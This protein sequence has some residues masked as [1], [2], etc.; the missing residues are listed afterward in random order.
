[1]LTKKQNLLET[2]RHGKPDRYVNQYEAFQM[3]YGNPYTAAY[4]MAAEGGPEVVNG[5]GVTIKFPK[6]MPG[7]FPVHDDAHIVCKDITHWRDYVKA[8]NIKFP[9]AAWEPFMAEVEKIDRN[10]YF[11]TPFVAPGIFEQCHYL[12]EIQ[13]CLINFYEEPEAMH[14]LIDYITEWEMQYAEELCRHFHPDALFHHDDWG[15]QISS[16]LSPDMFEEFYVPAYKKVYGYY[17]ELGVDVIVHHSDSYAANLVPHM[18]DIGI[19]IWQGV[20]DTNNIPELIDKYGDKIT[21]MGGI[22]SGRVDKPDW[23]PENTE[24]VVREAMTLYGKQK[25]AFIPCNT[26]GGP[27]S[28]YPGVYE[29]ITEKIEKVGKE[30][31]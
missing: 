18:I 31:W 11:V 26:M 21:F 28:I 12:Q 10:E 2:I 9:E 4:P 17:R 22:N 6:G 15:S 20:M 24:T 25:R 1:M 3:V 13:N 27:E 30:M 29:C 7:P 8:P 5:W 14:E 23:T 19:D 16:F